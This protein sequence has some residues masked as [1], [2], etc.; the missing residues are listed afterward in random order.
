MADLLNN[1]DFVNSLDTQLRTIDQL[2]PKYEVPKGIKQAQWMNQAN[3][4]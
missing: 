4:N 1:I 2:K 3:Q